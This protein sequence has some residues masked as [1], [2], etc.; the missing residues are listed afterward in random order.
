M[1]NRLVREID[2]DGDGHINEAEFIS[3]YLQL[4]ESQSDANFVK[5]IE[6]FGHVVVKWHS[7]N[8]HVCVNAQLR[9][10]RRSAAVRTIAQDT[11][12]HD[13]SQHS[14]SKIF[15]KTELSFSEF[16]H[17]VNM[18]IKPKPSAAEMRQLFAAYGKHLTP[19]CCNHCTI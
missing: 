17:G 8:A 7:D 11:R 5:W 2:A 15:A 19:N 16:S 13:R 9:K 4:F 18:M 10:L 14:G 1:N 12:A 3:H 6:Q